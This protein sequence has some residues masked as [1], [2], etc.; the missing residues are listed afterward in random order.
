MKVNVAVG[1][2]N[3]RVLQI[4]KATMASAVGADSKS[5]HTSVVGLDMPAIYQ[6]MPISPDF[7]PP[8]DNTGGDFSTSFTI[9]AAI[10]AQL[11][12]RAKAYP[13]PWT[14]HDQIATWLDPN[15]LLGS[16]FIENPTDNLL[17][18]ITLT[19][20]GEDVQVKRSY[21]SR[22]LNHS[23]TFLGYYFIATEMAVDKPHHLKLSLPKLPPGAFTGIFWENIE[24]EFK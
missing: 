14:T 6:Q 21:N 16:I 24:T 8:A 2:S 5:D 4:M 7:D 19:V 13:I 10:S 22:G 9:P 12:A 3:A 1:G 20:D 18:K 17:D 23:R 11:Q 15:R